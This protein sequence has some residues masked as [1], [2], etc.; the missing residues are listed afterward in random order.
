MAIELTLEDLRPF[1]P[2]LAA[3]K[4]ALMIEDATATAESVAPCLV[5]MPTSDPRYRAAKA[6]IRG[7]VLRWADYGTG[8]VTQQSAG[9]YSQTIDTRPVRRAMFW[10]SEINDLVKLCNQGRGKSK[11]FTIDTTPADTTRA[12]LFGQAWVNGPGPTGSGWD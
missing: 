11:A 10:P 4:A 6:I 5:D 1:A 9:P 2:D 3:D 8:A 12:R 7:A